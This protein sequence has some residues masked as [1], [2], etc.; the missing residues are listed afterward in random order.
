M[1]SKYIA[2][3]IAKISDVATA[4][5][6]YIE[7]YL[8]KLVVAMTRITN[9]HLVLY[10]TKNISE[11]PNSKSIACFKLILLS[12]F[13]QNSPDKLTMEHIMSNLESTLDFY[14]KCDPKQK[15]PHLD[16][17][18]S[19]KMQLFVHKY[20][21]KLYPSELK[22]P[23]ECL[24]YPLENLICNLLYWVGQKDLYFSPSKHP[25]DL[26][27]KHLN[28]QLVYVF[29]MFLEKENSPD[30]DM[31]SS[32][33]FVLRQLMTTLDLMVGKFSIP[34]QD[35]TMILMTHCLSRISNAM[36][37]HKMKIID[38]TLLE[39]ATR[40]ISLM[41]NLTNIPE[42]AQLIARQ[43][44]ITDTI[45]QLIKTAQDKLMLK[46]KSVFEKQCLAVLVNL[47]M[48]DMHV[49]AFILG[50]RV[51]GKAIDG[52]K[53]LLATFETLFNSFS[54]H[55]QSLFD[56]AQQISGEN[57]AKVMK[58]HK[59]IIIENSIEVE[60]AQQMEAFFTLCFLSFI[61]TSVVDQNRYLIPKVN[62]IFSESTSKS[63][64]D[65]LFLAK[66][67][68]FSEDDCRLVESK[69]EFWN[70]NILI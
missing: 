32:V 35:Q 11:I 61:I 28:E 42:C 22:A 65:F 12:I 17:Q 26:I 43:D 31:P 14:F 3:I 51:S 7:S 2:Q 69:I 50:P 63:L 19:L 25:S 62:Q 15:I 58:M 34:L 5:S 24:D 44:G 57:P 6:D 47:L 8:E 45:F 41:V 39:M 53:F 66:I 9:P 10:V 20:K 55:S 27:Q 36:D 59:K 13:A 46:S 52:L 48:R 68:V 21:I 4:N 37:S 64:A 40:L 67:A 29:E 49:C 23:K 16:T 33:Q 56:K 18:I 30:G 54:Q 60:T 70:T 38:P 1:K